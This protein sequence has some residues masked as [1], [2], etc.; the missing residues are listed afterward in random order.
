[1]ITVLVVG[2]TSESHP[3]D[4]RTEVS[5][6]L[7]NVT[8]QLSREFF[9]CRWVPYPAQYATGMAYADSK[10][11]AI[12]A[13]L[14]L[15]RQ[16][17]GPVVWLGY[18]QGADAVGDAANLLNVPQ[19]EDIRR[20]VRFVGLV[21]DPSRSVLQYCPKPPYPKGCYGIAGERLVT[22]DVPVWSLAATGDAIAS[23]PAGNPLRTLA[24]GTEFMSGDTME[25]FNRQKDHATEQRW[26]RWW[27]IRNWQTWGGA[28]AYAKGYIFD[29]RHTLAYT[30][31]HHLDILAAELAKLRA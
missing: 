27:D 17:E 10:A 13:L 20:K 5:G 28:L 14:I 22:A 24:D 7:K 25:W 15:T 3:G 1:V 19:Y 31:D 29:G 6:L 23:L 11:A 9:T 26:Q 4:A 18:S 12:K 30:E 8:D 2:G 21:A 16:T